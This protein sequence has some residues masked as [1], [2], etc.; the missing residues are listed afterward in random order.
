MVISVAAASLVGAGVARADNAPI[1]LGILVSETG[2]ASWLGDPEIK[3]AKLAIEEVN[4]QGGING[5]PLSL[6]IYNDE[7]SPEKAVIG[8]RKLIEQDK[9]A[10]IIGTSLV[11]TSKAIAPLVKD[12]G[13]V[14]VSLSGGYVPENSFMFAGSV[15]TTHMQDTIMDWMKAKGLK[16]VALLA[17]S[18]STG[19][20]AAEAIKKVAPENGIALVALERM[21]ANDVDVTPQ[22]SRIRVAAPDVVIAWLTGKPAGVVV[23][24]YA[25][26]G[27]TYPLF[28]SHGNISYS[29][30][31]SIKAFQ[32]DVLL[33]PSSKDVVWGD[34]P[35]TD[36]QRARNEAFHKKYHER[37]KQYADFGPPVAY[38]AV[39]LV[40]EAMKK[41]GLQPA[42]MRD[43]LETLKGH[44]GLVAVYDLSKTDH[45]G[46]GRKDTVI[47]QVKN[48]A[49][50]LNWK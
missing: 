8:A 49:F 6:V 39:M 7:S 13:P 40:A 24:N 23:K 10:A 9:V 25:Q 42:K 4:A 36:P 35:A 5:R 38:D 44:V 29:F 11:A 22:L 50:S 18:D 15:Q 30:I 20:V 2:P 12:A 46:T 34:L 47:M 37:Y 1:P 41:G 19:Q 28:L 26:L 45:R 17:S 43:A 27:L 48:G 33:M 32:P 3:G 16:K 14:A 21:N 31:N